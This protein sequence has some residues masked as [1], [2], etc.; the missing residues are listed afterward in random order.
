MEAP[1]DLRFWHYLAFAIC[2]VAFA[3]AL[4]AICV[5]IDWAFSHY[6]GTV[7]AVVALVILTAGIRSWWMDPEA[8]GRRK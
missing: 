1:S 7:W 6:P 3:S 4:G 8:P 2:G 5:A